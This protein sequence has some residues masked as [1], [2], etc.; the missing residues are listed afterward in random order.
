MTS[1]RGKPRSQTDWQAVRARLAEAAAST[2]A[3]LDPPAELAE[4]ILRERSRRLAKRLDQRAPGGR[5]TELIIFLIGGQRHAVECRYLREVRRAGPITPIPGT[6]EILEGLTSLRGD[7]I[8]AFDLCRLL[9]LPPRGRSNGPSSGG[10]MLVFG[11]HQPEFAARVD[12]VL[13][14]VSIPL[15]PLGTAPSGTGDFVGSSVINIA[16]AVSTLLDGATLLR[17]GALTLDRHIE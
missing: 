16:G 10:W 7:V 3:A 1:S 8:P 9:D 2:A 4:A 6:A 17:S 13:D 12:D 11:E 14:F 15:E 5:T